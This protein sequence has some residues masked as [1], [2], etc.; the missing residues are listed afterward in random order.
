MLKKNCLKKAKKLN[1]KHPLD[2]PEATT[3]LAD[4]VSVD[5]TKV[6]S[7]TSKLRRVNYE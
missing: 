5:E 6:K 4:E 3:Q 1:K 7:T 2:A